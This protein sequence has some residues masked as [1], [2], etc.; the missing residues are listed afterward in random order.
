MKSDFESVREIFKQL[1]ALEVE[2]NTSIASL[3]LD[4]MDLCALITAIEERFYFDI[5]DEIAMSFKIV[6]EI[7]ALVEDMKGADLCLKTS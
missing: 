2:E 3:N 1:F 7:V 5:P 4:G 6:E